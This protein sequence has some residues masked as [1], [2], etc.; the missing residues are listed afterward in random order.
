MRFVYSVHIKILKF[1]FC[2]FGM[3]Y[4]FYRQKNLV[5]LQTTLRQRLHEFSRQDPSVALSLFT[6]KVNNIDDVLWGYYTT[7]LVGP[8]FKGG[9]GPKLDERMTYHK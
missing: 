8:N 2:P 4:T 7:Q 9:L 5:V 1:N 3:K 6:S